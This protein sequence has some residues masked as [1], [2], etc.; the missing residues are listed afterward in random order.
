[1][2]ES[3]LFSH[4]GRKRERKGEEAAGKLCGSMNAGW[5]GTAGGAFD[6]GLT[7]RPYSFCIVSSGQFLHSYTPRNRTCVNG[8]PFLS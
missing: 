4:L 2:V 1:M 5:V 6:A 7:S 3:I 8:Q